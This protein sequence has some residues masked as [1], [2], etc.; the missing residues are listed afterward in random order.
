MSE[1]CA[2]RMIEPWQTEATSSFWKVI[3]EKVAP[4]SVLVAT[5]RPTF[6]DDLWRMLACKAGDG[7]FK[8][9]SFAKYNESMGPGIPVGFTKATPVAVPQ[10][11]PVGAYNDCS[12]AGFHQL[13]FVHAV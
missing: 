5:A 3:L 12:I 13:R 8:R 7:W 1:F 9:S 11:V 10:R 4:L 6:G 2:E